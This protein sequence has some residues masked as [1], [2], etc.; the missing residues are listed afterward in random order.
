MYGKWQNWRNFGTNTWIS[1]KIFYRIFSIV[2]VSDIY[3][4]TCIQEK[5]QGGTGLDLEIFSN[6]LNN[7]R[8]IGEKCHSPNLRSLKIIL[9]LFSAICSKGTFNELKMSFPTVYNMNK[10]DNFHFRYFYAQKH[11]QCKGVKPP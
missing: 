3:P 5:K 2:N 11:A 10:F 6:F 4:R 1:W 7:L 8:H 9:R